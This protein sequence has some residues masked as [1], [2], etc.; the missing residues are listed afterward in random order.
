MTP[1]VNAAR[2]NASGYQVF[3]EDLPNILSTTSGY[4]HNTSEWPGT[5]YD[6]SGCPL[7]FNWRDQEEN[8]FTGAL[9]TPR[10]L[11]VAWHA[12]TPSGAMTF[13]D[14]SG[15][16]LT[17]TIIDAT[18]TNYSDVRV[19]LL[20]SAVTN[21]A[22]YRLA[23]EA[24]IA[25]ILGQTLFCLDRPRTIVTRR[26]VSIDTGYVIHSA[27]STSGALVDGDSAQ[28]AFITRADELVLIGTHAGSFFFPIASAYLTQ[29]NAFCAEVGETAQTV[30]VDAA[31][32]AEPLTAAF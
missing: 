12:T 30:S 28:P 5:V 16:V 17:R 1:Y 8:A 3:G 32:W 26:A 22:V 19:L 24:S 27:D 7:S 15:T 25:S 2:I 31:D 11:L 4:T 20:S 9:I 21:C 23:T 13:V 10:H 29:I 6:F 14:R 18:D